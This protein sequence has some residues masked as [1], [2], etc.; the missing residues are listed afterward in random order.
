V[1]VLADGKEVARDVDLKLSTTISDID[2]S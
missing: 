2:I 1:K